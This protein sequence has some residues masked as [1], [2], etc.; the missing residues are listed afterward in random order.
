MLPLREGRI[1][2][3]DMRQIYTYDFQVK[4]V[5]E[6]IKLVLDREMI[7]SE[8]ICNKYSSS[9][10]CLVNGELIKDISSG[11]YLDYFM[12]EADITK[13]VHEGKNEVSMEYRSE[14]L[15][16]DR[17]FHTPFIIGPFNLSGNFVIEPPENSIR[18]GDWCLNGYPFYAG[19][20]A[21]KQT[22]ELPVWCRG[23]R[24]LLSL[25]KLANAA[26]LLV[27]GQSLGKR[28]LPPW[29]FDISNFNSCEHLDLEIRIVNTPQNL[30]CS[31]PIPSGLFGP[32]EIQVMI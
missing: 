14:Y 18:I 9:L 21:F 7:K 25:G 4:E 3:R 27:N 17:K 12:F 5:P 8:L 30:F 31:E 23:R 28:V 19:E 32:V 2:N 10:K 15:E 26:E 11:T 22:F 6:K 13:L 29:E 20:A 16:T 1:E 24:L